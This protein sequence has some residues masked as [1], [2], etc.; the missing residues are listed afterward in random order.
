MRAKSSAA[1]MPRGRESLLPS[2][3]VT[4]IVFM[5]HQLYYE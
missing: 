1:W 5:F 2:E 3:K 4:V